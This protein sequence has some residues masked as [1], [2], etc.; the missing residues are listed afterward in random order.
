MNFNFLKRLI[1]AIVLFPIL[2]LVLLKGSHSVIT[3][4]VALSILI[5]WHE[6]IRLFDFSRGYFL[7]GSLTL[8]FVIYQSSFISWPILFF[9]VFFMSFLPFLFY[10]RRENFTSQFFPLIA[11]LFYLM[12]GFIPILVLSKEYPR[13]YLLFLFSVVFATDTGAYLAGKLLGRRPFFSQISP[14]KTWEGFFGGI[15][16]ALLVGILLREIFSL[17]S[18]KTSMLI[19]LVLSLSETCGDLFESAVK[20][21]VGKK[22]AGALIPGHGGLLDRIDGVLFAS[23]FFLLFLEVIN[24]GVIH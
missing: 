4:L 13:E 20:R 3:V 10:F 7:L 16:L 19:S 12:L 18:L 2:V 24:N 11:G 1:S 21:S 23:P 15:F 8:L 5:C 9:L 14:K 17:W 22:D 6:W